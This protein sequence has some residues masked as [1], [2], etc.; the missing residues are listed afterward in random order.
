MLERIRNRSPLR[1][2]S[3]TRAGRSSLLPLVAIGMI[4]SPTLASAVDSG[5]VANKTTQT[6]PGPE[7]ILQPYEPLTGGYTHDSNDTGFTDVNLS[8]K[9]RLFPLNYLP[10][11]FRPYFAMATRFGFYWGSRPKSP[12]IGKSYNPLLLWRFLPRQQPIRDRDPKLLEKYIDVIPYAHQSN[13]QL[14]HTPAQYDVQLASLKIASYTNNFI[15]RGWDYVGIVWKDTYFSKSKYQL[16]TYV[17]GNYFLQDGFLQG[18]PDEYHS[19]ENNPEGKPRK[20]VDG[21]SFI[22]EY[23]SSY[24]HYAVDNGC[25]LSRPNITVKYS[26]GYDTPFQYSTIRGEFGFQLMSLPL[27]LWVQHG[28][29]SSLAMYYQKVTSLGLEVR[30]E[31]F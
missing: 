5:L 19:W 10:R 20:A 22:A 23:P 27:A 14:I 24:A 30:F 11:W 6:Q 31:N 25:F 17:G 26:T 8:L 16:S 3:E 9:I 21:L 1:R 18:P 29:M 12:V 13:G 7:Q 28:Y 4:A 15:H 2:S